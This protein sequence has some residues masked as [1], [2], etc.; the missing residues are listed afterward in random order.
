MAKR[1]PLN[2]VECKVNDSLSIILINVCEVMGHDDSLP[3]NA[4]VYVRKDNGILTHIANARNDGWGGDSNI[5]AI[6][7]ETKPVIDELEAIVGTFVVDLGKWSFNASLP[8]VVELMASALLSKR[9]TF[10]KI[11]DL[12]KW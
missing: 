2:N 8:L 4:E 3:F 9:G 11:E 5:D 6:N 10:F 1:T 7:K 12:L